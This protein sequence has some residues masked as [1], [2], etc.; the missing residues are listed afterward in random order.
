LALPGEGL[1]KGCVR[2]RRSSRV[3]SSGFHHVLDV[4]AFAVYPLIIV[5]EGDG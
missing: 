4:I 2:Q 5:E 3:E 1:G